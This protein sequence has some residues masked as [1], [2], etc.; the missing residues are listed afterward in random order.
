MKKILSLLLC[1]CI[2]FSI[3]L[4]GIETVS[5]E[6][7]KL[8]LVENGVSKCSIVLA[9]NCKAYER[10]A[11]E[12]MQ[13]YLKKISGADI[14][15]ITDASLT[16]GAEIVIGETNRAQTDLS[17]LEDDG[18]KVYSD[19]DK[20]VICGK[21]SRGTIYGVYGFL[22]KYLDCRWYTSE[23]IVTPE[24]ATVSIDTNI[25]FMQNSYFEYRD[26]DWLS[27]R[28]QEYSLANQ[29][30]GGVYRSLSAAQG[31]TVNYL[32]NFAHSLSNTYCRSAVYFED[33]PEYFAYREEMGCRIGDQLC[34]TNP[35][36]VEIVKNEVLAVLE[37][38]YTGDAVIISLTQHDNRNYCECEQCKASETRY[39]TQS[40]VM[41]EFVNKIAA[42]VKAAG[43]DNVAIDT[44]A[45]QYTRSAP[46]NIVPADN[47]IVRLC[48]IECCFA[49]TLDDAKCSENVEF[50]TDL[51]AW[52]EICDRLYVWDYA[53]NYRETISFFADFGTLQR[54]MQIFAE[55]GVKGVY[56]EGNY[57]MSTCD[58][59]FGELRAY[60]ISRLL[61]DPYMD[62]YAEMDGFLKA[63][64]GDGWELI[65][66][67][68]D[69]TI[70]DS[71]SYDSHL[72]I[73]EHSEN[74]FETFKRDEIE[75]CNVIWYEAKKAAK[76]DWQYENVCRS[77]LCWR[78][79]K[80]SN[81]KCEFSYLRLPIRWMY[82]KEL[83][84]DDLVSFGITRIGESDFRDFTECR[85]LII[86][87]K[88]YNWKVN[89]EAAWIFGLN[90]LIMPIYEKVKAYCL[91]KGI[92]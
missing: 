39:G 59:E 69:M 14:R 58:G 65:R 21:G 16:T 5:A 10:T 41:L 36:V 67:F 80:C 49:H 2:V 64:Y 19:S 48:S 11:A 81:A 38:G 54:N 33:H 53:N 18:F 31:G 77:E 56:S 68:I 52:N 28:D 42:A 46:K 4:A 85:A 37:G 76:T 8:L 63:Y 86:F 87:G 78:Y 71:D 60:L 61:W 62:Y 88:V 43:Y 75:R 13:Y 24:K 83:L 44:F 45:Y 82:E 35:D 34:L 70:A 3:C 91:E 79:W 6:G 27:P 7:E 22:R 23:L 9:L 51:R 55:T 26:T 57:Y 20:L 29:L 89:D 72:G 84:F 15:I 50:M 40:G 12:K 90:N 92:I 30:N 1:V 66:E 73:F 47:V 74:T 32:G 17:A 25:G